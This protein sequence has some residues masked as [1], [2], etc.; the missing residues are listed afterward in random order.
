MR[1]LGAEVEVE[2]RRGA[3]GRGGPSRAA[4]SRC[5]D[6]LRERRHADAPA[7][8]APRRAGGT[9]RARRRRVALA[10]APRADRRAARARWA[11][12]WR[13]RTGMRRSSSKGGRRFAPIR[14][15]LPV[16]S[17]QVKSC[18]LLAGLYAD[19]GRT[20]VVEPHPS[21]DHTERML[22]AAGARVRRKAG[23]PA[24]WPAERLAAVVDFRFPGT[25]RR[26]RRSSSPR[27]SCRARDSA[28]RRRAQPDAYR[29]AR[30]ARAH[31][32][33]GRALQPAVGG[34]RAGRRPRGGARRADRDRDR[35]GRG[36]AAR[37]RAAALRACGRNGAGAT[38]SSAER[39]SCASRSRTAS[40]P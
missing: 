35:A 39:R 28:P 4:G 26:R 24:V 9:L 12:R 14:Y 3:R 21:R 32:R 19:G 31:G 6:R 36:A 15:E 1:A 38:A 29:V 33:A 10:A 17:A 16:A 22:E 34:R 37:R 23:E 7:A 18:V 40:R 5:P 25:S 13:R 8:R 11:P 2:G 20:T 30:R 27:R